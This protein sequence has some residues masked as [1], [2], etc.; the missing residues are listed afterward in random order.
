MKYP[1]LRTITCKCDVCMNESDFSHD[2]DT[3]SY[4]S[5]SG[6][7]VCKNC[8]SD[9]RESAKVYETPVKWGEV[10]E[11]RVN[12]KEEEYEPDYDND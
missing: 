2:T 3:H 10:P 8:L 11:T 7:V 12:Y 6:M 1:P 4:D 5:E 9:F